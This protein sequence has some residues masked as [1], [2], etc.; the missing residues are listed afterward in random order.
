MRR[1]STS[2]PAGA[3]WR[4]RP[5]P[6]RSP[7]SSPALRSWRRKT[8]GRGPR[9]ARAVQAGSGARRV[10]VSLRE[11]GRVVGLWDGSRV[12]QIVSNLPRQRDQVRGGQARGDLH[13]RGGRDGAALG[14]GITGSGSTRRTRRRSSSGSSER[15]PTGTTAGWGSACTSAAGS[16]R[17]TAARS[18]SRARSAPGRR[19]SSSCRGPGRRGAAP[20]ALPG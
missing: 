11:C 18:A 20:R 16:R 19:S 12:D 17:R 6:R 13:R 8:A 14:R 15:C 9:R 1:G 4:R 2:L 3:P 5:S 10:A 7:T